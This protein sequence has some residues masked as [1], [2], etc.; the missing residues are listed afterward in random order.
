M[1]VLLVEDND[2]LREV[3]VEVLQSAGYRVL[4]LSCAEELD[5]E[6]SLSPFSVAVLDLNLPGE[7]GLS[8]ATRLRAIYPYI[9]I[10]IMTIRDLLED[11][12]LGYDLGADLYLTKPTDPQELCAAVGALGRRLNTFALAEAHEAAWWL[13]LE[14]K[15]LYTPT[16]AHTSLRDTEALVLHALLLAP[17]GFLEHWQLLELFRKPLDDRGKGQLEALMSRLRRKLH[18]H[19][20]P[21]QALR[22]IRRMGYR[23]DLPL[24]IR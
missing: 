7:N 9:A 13:D 3:T 24:R 20:V 22:A 10:V 15:R 18:A 1:N 11:K 6:V 2:A 4:A 23:L 5:R 16:G 14:R 8:L 12:L 19:G 21:C 17:N